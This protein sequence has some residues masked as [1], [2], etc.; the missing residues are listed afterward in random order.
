MKEKLLRYSLIA[1]AILYASIFIGAI[2]MPS[3]PD[4]GWHLRY[5]EYFFKTGHVLRTNPL[6]QLMPD[7]RW[8]NSSWLTDL[9][10]YQVYHHAGFI[11]LSLLSAAVVVMTFYFMAKSA[12][13]SI[14]EKS[15][16]FP[17][18]FY[19]LVTLNF[20]SF[21]GQQLSLLFLSIL[22]F[23][24][25]LY[26]KNNRTSLVLIPLFI[27]WGNLHGE[28]I[29]GLAVFAIWVGVFLVKETI[30]DYKFRFAD[31][32]KDNKYL[33][34]SFVGSL[35]GVLINPFGIGV[36]QEALGHFSDPLQKNVSEFLAPA[37]F[38]AVW[39]HLLFCLLVVMFGMLLLGTGRKNWD[40][41]PFYFPS[42]LLLLLTFWIKRYA[43]P[44]YYSSIFLF[45]P[46]VH[47]F[48][49]ETRK[50]AE[51]AGLVISA[52]FLVMVIAVKHP[53]R[54][55]D[56]SWDKYCT[57]NEG[58]S[59]KAAEFVL[60]HK[61]NNEKLLTIYDW[62]GYLDW[63]FRQI[64]PTIDG[65]MHL[66]RDRNG[67]SAFAYYFPIEQNKL[68]IDKTPYD[69]VLAAKDKAV[70]DRLVEL[71]HENKWKELYTDHYSAVFVRK[72]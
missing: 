41:I 62:G 4:L 72:D 34:T 33:L 46:V 14:F 21:R 22:Y 37:D 56:F 6:T 15:I 52:I 40:K 64:T 39:W 12:T 2:Y 10:S 70:Y 5:G 11:G 19:F 47:F 60:S 50:R 23:F 28:Y 54:L 53:I 67:F 17:I 71:A 36:Y 9:I 35:A 24:L 57:I 20:I 55:R 7:Y 51:Q 43:W 27:V 1:N 8:N 3:D 42:L 26:K 16:I 61:L 63:N 29:L 30:L 68:D 48:E 45:Q 59:P 31:L 65:R 13:L 58:C 38:S 69:T 44:F 49:P 18:I 25:S 66:W 32:I